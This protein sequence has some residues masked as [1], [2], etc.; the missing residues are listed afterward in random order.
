MNQFTNTSEL[1]NYEVKTSNS[2]NYTPANTSS[3]SNSFP[4][5]ME[6]G[7]IVDYKVL[8]FTTE[9]VTPQ[10]QPEE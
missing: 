1:M 4:N 10:D 7:V 3:D 6:N 5:L 8:D 2:N 9:I